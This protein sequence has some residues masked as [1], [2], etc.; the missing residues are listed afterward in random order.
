MNE[1]I[2][3][4]M[5]NKAVITVSIIPMVGRAYHVIKNGGGL[6]G[7]WNALIFGTNTPKKEGE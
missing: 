7:I 3:F 5:N 6:K 2:N 1:A 4:L